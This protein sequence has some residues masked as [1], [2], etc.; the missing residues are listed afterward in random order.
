MTSSITIR[1]D[2]ALKSEALAKAKRCGD[3]LSAVMRGALLEY[4]AHER[5]SAGISGRQAE[6]E[7]L[8]R[9][10]AAKREKLAQLICGLSRKE[11]A[12]VKAVNRQVRVGAL[13]ELWDCFLSLPTS[14]QMD[15]LKSPRF[16]G[17]AWQSLLQANPFVLAGVFR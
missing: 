11:I 12:R 14:Q 2:E 5:P 3:S 7:R 6:I 8:N 1:V 16:E 17:M 10:V 4:L 15:A 13:S 9:Q